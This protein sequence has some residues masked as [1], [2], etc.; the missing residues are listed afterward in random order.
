MAAITSANVLI[1]NS[2]EGISKG[3]K[4]TRNYRRCRVT[5]SNQGGTSG[6]IPA[7]VFNLTDIYEVDSYGINNAGTWTS[8]PVIVDQTTDVNGVVRNTGFLTT[9]LT[10]GAP[11]STTGVLEVLVTGRTI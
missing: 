9:N 11:A 1:L 2:W 6:D 4:T 10:T 5:L 7:S 3:N 8:M